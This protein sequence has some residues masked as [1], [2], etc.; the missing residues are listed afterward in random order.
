[1]KALF[2]SAA[3]IAT[4]AVGPALAQAG[5]DGAKAMHKAPMTRA[6]V[7]ARVQEHFAKL[8]ADK[9]GFVTKAEAEA[10]KAEK[11][12]MK[13]G[14]HDKMFDRMDAD[15]DGSISR[16][17]FDAAHKAMAEKMA[18]HRQMRMGHGPLGPRMFEIADT[19]NDGRVSLEEATNAALARFDKADTDRDGILTAE[20]MR[21]A[22]EAMRAKMHE[23]ML[24]K[25]AG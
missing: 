24:D 13:M 6:A 2:V 7:V 5:A 25:P 15:K 18:K 16:A 21:A 22:H 9:D 1:M 12:K 19:D 14:G 17:E 20:E 3:A 8:D 10:M 11:R 23:K 4:L